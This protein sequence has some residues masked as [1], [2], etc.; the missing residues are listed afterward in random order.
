[1][2]E[3]EDSDGAEDDEHVGEVEEEAIE[4]HNWWDFV[5]RKGEKDDLQLPELTDYSIV[6][7]PDEESGRN[8]DMPACIIVDGPLSWCSGDER[9]GCDDVIVSSEET[10][11][12][13]ARD[14]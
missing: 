9:E 2:D 4:D 13:K 12:Q 10:A 14:A 1:M 8:E 5:F 3:D 7:A 11:D 6:D